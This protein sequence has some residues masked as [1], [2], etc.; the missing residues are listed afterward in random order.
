MQLAGLPVGLSGRHVGRA[1]RWSARL[2]QRLHPTR[3][4]ASSSRALLCLAQHRINGVCQQHSHLDIWKE[5]ACTGDHNQMRAEFHSCHRWIECL[6]L[7]RRHRVRRSAEQCRGG[8]PAVRMRRGGAVHEQCER[9]AQ[10]VQLLISATTCVRNCWPATL[11]AR[12]RHRH[13]ELDPMRYRFFP[14]PLGRICCE[15][16]EGEIGSDKTNGVTSATARQHH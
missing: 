9:D 3:A 13:G 10:L 16:F 15:P 4:A 7:R 5:P 6:A 14:A 1:P 8:P 12:R 2:R 11:S